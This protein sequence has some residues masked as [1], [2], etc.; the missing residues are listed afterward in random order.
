MGD[1]SP[2]QIV[3]FK[4]DLRVEDHRALTR[5]AMAGPVLPLYIV[6]PALW[7]QADMSGRQWAFIAE[8]LA[9][10]RED[11]GKLGQSLVVRVGRATDILE[12]IAAA[13]PVAKLWSHEETG[14]GW[15]YERDKAVAQWCM[16]AGLAWEEMQMHGV[17]RRLDTRNGWARRWDTLMGEPVC[18]PPRALAPLEDVEPGAIPTANDLGLDHDPCPGRQAGSRA[19]GEACLESFLFQR[20]ENYRREMSSPMTGFESCSRLSP[21]LAWGTLSMREIAQATWRRQRELKHAPEHTGGWRPSL[22]SFTGRLHW[23]CHFMQ[24]LEDQPA[25]EFED[26]HPAYRGMRPTEPD[27]ARLDAWSAGET[28]LPFVDACM[29]ALNQTGWM[30]FRMRAMLMAVASYHLWLPWRATG[31]HLARQFTDY[32]PGIHWPQTQM[33]SGTTGINTVRIYNPVKQGHDQDPSGNFVRRWVPELAN[34]P[35]EFIHEPWMWEDAGAVL[36]K[37]YPF[38][39]IDHKDAAKQARERIYAVRKG[40][41]YRENANAIQDKHGSRKSGIPNRGQKPGPDGKQARRRKT[42]QAPSGQLSLGFE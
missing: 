11:L 30:N 13:R 36:G 26:L 3:W 27:A 12:Q 41:A 33:Q 14:N 24:K 1:K 31:L 37:T 22:R 20:G 4:R 29:R 35:A 21:H 2:L 9:G 15:T 34:V 19:A 40:S 18:D 8:S 38:P 23:H 28:G 42:A 39:I 5:A 6:E 16:V 17:V 32:E 25:L 10:L 7:K